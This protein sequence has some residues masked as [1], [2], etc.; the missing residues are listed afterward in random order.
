MYYVNYY[1]KVKNPSIAVL[2]TIF[3]KDLK[4]I[5]IILYLS[6]SFSNYD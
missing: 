5:K 2:I 6:Y 3:C 4:C 1:Y